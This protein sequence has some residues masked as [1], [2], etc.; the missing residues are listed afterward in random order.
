MEAIHE[1]GTGE[2]TC[3]P[4]PNNNA[5]YCQVA[6]RDTGPGLQ[7]EIA[8]RI[9]NEIGVSD[10]PTGTGFGTYFS[11]YLLRRSGAEIRHD[12][13]YEDG[14]QFLLRFPAVSNNNA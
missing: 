11:A 8:D 7:P 2:I 13:S 9:F 10:K 4:I 12:P 1:H 14:T 5:E 6:I 3:L